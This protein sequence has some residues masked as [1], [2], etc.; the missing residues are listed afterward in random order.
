MTDAQQIRLLEGQL[1][2]SE[3]SADVI[4][5]IDIL[6]DLAWA[7]SDTD[8]SRAYAL[9][10]TAYA[11]A[12]SPA[13]GAPPYEAG[14]A[15]SL[16]TLGYLNQRLGNYPLGLSQLL[17]AREIF[18]ALQ[19]DE[20]LADVLDG[21]AGIYAQIGDYPEA[22]TLMYAQL[23]A[24]QRIGDRRRVTNAYNNLANIYLESKE[25]ERAIE[26]FYRNLQIAEEIGYGRIVSLSYLNLA[27]TYLAALLALLAL[28]AC[29][30]Q[31]TPTPAPAP[32]PTA[33]PTLAAPTAAPTEAP[34]ATP[35]AAHARIACGVDR[36]AEIARPLHRAFEKSRHH[37]RDA[38]HALR[39]MVRPP[40]WAT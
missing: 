18:E 4:H 11:L 15:Y 33:I 19:L 39:V 31:A 12:N 5:T 26:T 13:D 6:N 14:M 34:T 7:L 29:G 24:A 40:V 28:A 20:G 10:E 8:M 22:L 16:R 32:T 3:N 27:E 21:T 23:D 36:L 25:Y 30:G 17:K 35:T 1:A 38:V 9:S 2:D 37:Q